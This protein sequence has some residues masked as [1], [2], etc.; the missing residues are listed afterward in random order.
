MKIVILY[1]LAILSLSAA[2]FELSE[3]DRLRLLNDDDDSQAVQI[4]SHEQ[5]QGGEV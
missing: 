2:A 3:E 5:E 1:C 4:E